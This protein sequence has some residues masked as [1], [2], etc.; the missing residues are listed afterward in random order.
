MRRVRMVLVAGA[1]ARLRT[2]QDRTDE[3]EELDPPGG[4]ADEF[5]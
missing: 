1:A 3:A 4:G 2:R 5:R